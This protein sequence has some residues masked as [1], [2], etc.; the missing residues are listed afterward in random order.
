MNRPEPSMNRPEPSM[1][2]PEPSMNRPEPSR[3]NDRKCIFSTYN[4]LITLFGIG[5]TIFQSK[6]VMLS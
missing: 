4:Y 2:R 3:K 6:F 1:K 5:E